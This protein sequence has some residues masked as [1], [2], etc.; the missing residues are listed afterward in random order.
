MENML[1]KLATHAVGYAELE[2]E[3]GL[4]LCGIGTELWNEPRVQLSGGRF[5]ELA[6]DKSVSLSIFENGH[7]YK[8]SFYHDSVKFIALFYGE[9][10]RELI[11]NANVSESDMSID[12]YIASLAEELASND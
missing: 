7:K 12:S 6:Q 8:A 11:A 10:V 3:L 5:I 9:A 4:G 1:D 2:K